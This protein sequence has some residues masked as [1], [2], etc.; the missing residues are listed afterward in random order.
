MIVKPALAVIGENVDHLAGFDPSVRAAVDHAL[1]LMLERG[2]A[3]DFLL[4]INE[5]LAGDG[6]SFVAGDSGLILQG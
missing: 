2:E 4:H 6:V 1:E 3:R 5:M